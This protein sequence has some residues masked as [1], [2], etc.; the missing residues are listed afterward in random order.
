MRQF[1]DRLGKNLQYRDLVFHPDESDVSYTQILILSDFW[2]GQ[3][4]KPLQA[5]GIPTRCVEGDIFRCPRIRADKGAAVK[6]YAFDRDRI[7]ST[8]RAGD[9]SH[10]LGLAGQ[11]GSGKT[12]AAQLFI[13][14]HNFQSASY[15]NPL[16]FAV[17]PFLDAC[18]MDRPFDWSSENFKLLPVPMPPVTH[19]AVYHA[20]C[21]VAGLT[22]GEGNLFEGD[23]ETEVIPYFATK[24]FG[25]ALQKWVP[26]YKEL[27]E[28]QTVTIRRILQIFGTEI[29]RGLTDDLWLAKMLPELEKP[30]I[31]VDDVRFVNEAQFLRSK[32]ARIIGITRDRG[33]YHQDLHASELEMRHKWSEIVDFSIENEG[34]IS[35]LHDALRR[36]YI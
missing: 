3:N 10:I 11:K 12:T 6:V 22:D 1:R 2:G 16:K 8:Y 29:G 35:Q 17:E 28:D 5:F 19:E 20:F 32:G 33:E 26:I 30:R 24:N 18:G 9:G 23:L 36:S 13:R 25:W 31:L 14:D 34:S 21:R 7:Y 27:L 4:E 15:A